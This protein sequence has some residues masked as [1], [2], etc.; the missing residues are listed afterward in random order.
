MSLDCARPSVCPKSLV[1][2]ISGVDLIHFLSSSYFVKAVT[3]LSTHASALSSVD[4]AIC[5][6]ADGTSTS[7]VSLRDVTSDD[8]A[9]SDST[10]ATPCHHVKAASERSLFPPGQ[11]TP[12]SLPL[13]IIRL[14]AICLDDLASEDAP[15]LPSA[16]R[17]RALMR[18]ESLGVCLSKSEKLRDSQYRSHSSRLIETLTIPLRVQLL[19]HSNL[20]FTCIKFS[21]CF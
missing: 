20:A 10:E 9:R 8:P 12:S 19:Y 1:S 4:S 11:R 5:L 13:A 21:R 16:H 6:S 18:V 17:D 14:L 2:E 15:R 7:S 3:D